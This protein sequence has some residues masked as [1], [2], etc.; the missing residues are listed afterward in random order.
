MVQIIRF[1]FHLPKMY[2]ARSVKALMKKVLRGAVGLHG[3]HNRLID[4]AML[5][6]REERLTMLRTGV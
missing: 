3:K 6:Y 2:L 4:M 1:F 5:V